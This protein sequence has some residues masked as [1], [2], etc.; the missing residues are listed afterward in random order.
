MALPGDL[1][2][3]DVERFARFSRPGHAITGDRYR[4]GAE[5]RSG[6]GWEY[7]H[8]MVDDHL[9]LAYT[10]LYPD[11]RAPSV[12]AFTE[13]ALG[14]F[15][16][17]GIEVKRLM[18]DNH[19]SHARNNSLRELLSAKGIRHLFIEIR[20]PQTNGKVERY[21]QTLKREYHGCVDALQNSARVGWEPPVR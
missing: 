6:V 3:I 8:S 19:L 16:A 11:E 18:S 5:K 10:A 13:R 4:S 21:H 2:H 7:A 17:H 1:V 12:T 15:V 14:F 20:R 9:R